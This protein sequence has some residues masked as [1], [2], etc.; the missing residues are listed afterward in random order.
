M[1]HAEVWQRC[2]KL[3][4]LIQPWLQTISSV[5]QELGESRHA[6]TLLQNLLKSVSENTLVRYLAHLLKFVGTL[7]DL[8]VRWES[9]RQ[10][11][12]V[13]AL[14]SMHKSGSHV[15]N[16]LKAVR[17]AAKTFGLALPDLYGGLLVGVEAR[18][19]S[20]RKE[21]LPLPIYVLAYCERALL[22]ESGSVGFR[23]FLGAILISASASLRFSDAQHILWTSIQ[24]AQDNVRAISYRTKSSRCRFA[25]E[26]FKVITETDR[27]AAFFFIAGMMYMEHFPFNS[28]FGIGSVAIGCR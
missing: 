4:A 18:I 23:L 19:T 24:A 10:L 26:D 1:L 11:E 20:D 14:L 5:L 17:W 7:Q 8:N 28:S 3:W 16:G 9:I 25:N 21:A 12:V 6:S 2:L 15:T 27:M 22:L 13:D